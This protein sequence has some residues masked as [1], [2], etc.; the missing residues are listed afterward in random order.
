MYIDYVKSVRN[1]LNGRIFRAKKTFEVNSGRGCIEK[2]TIVSIEIE[3]LKQSF[4]RVVVYPFFN[5]DCSVNWSKKFHVN[6]PINGNYKTLP[7]ELD[8]WFEPVTEAEK[9][10]Q[11]HEE[12]KKRLHDI[13][14]EIYFVLFLII[15]FTVILLLINYALLSDNL[16]EWLKAAVIIFTTGIFSIIFSVIVIAT[17]FHSISRKKLEK[18]EQEFAKLVK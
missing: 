4:C 10:W 8:E 3:D 18:L 1:Q 14:D 5:Q 2:G 9:I 7:D 16:Q 11:K 12:I 6:F 13:E 17:V 15:F